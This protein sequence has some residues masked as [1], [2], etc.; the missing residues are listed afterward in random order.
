MPL[1]GSR[2]E[3]WSWAGGE[4]PLQFS[5]YI[6]GTI[7]IL[8]GLET[9]GNNVIFLYKKPNVI[10]YIKSQSFLLLWNLLESFKVS[11]RICRICY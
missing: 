11:E 1:S 8:S 7:E 9:F 2:Q 3:C 6:A 10:F 4:Y 5:L